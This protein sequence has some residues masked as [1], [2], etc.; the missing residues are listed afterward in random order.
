MRLLMIFYSRASDDLPQNL[1]PCQTDPKVVG[2][3]NAAVY[4][5]HCNRN[6]TATAEYK[7]LPLEGI[8]AVYILRY[9]SHQLAHS[10]QLHP[11]VIRVSESLG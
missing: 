11:R 1:P 7:H 2:I 8:A 10:L 4:S 3:F 5:C 9:F 6:F